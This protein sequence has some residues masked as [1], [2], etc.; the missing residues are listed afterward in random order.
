[1]DL[2]C[3]MLCKPLTV[4]EEWTQ[5][6][7]STWIWNTSMLRFAWASNSNHK[8]ST[9]SQCRKGKHQELHHSKKFLLTSNRVKDLE[10]AI[11]E[12]HNKNSKQ[13]T[14]DKAII[15]L[16]KGPNLSSS[17]QIHSMPNKLTTCITKIRTAVI[18]KHQSN[19]AWVLIPKTNRGLRTILDL[20][21]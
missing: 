19:G 8:I 2:R 3:Q 4:A 16:V 1:M 7:H 9:H 14:W 10:S 12:T 5:I 11:H 13:W 21:I 20:K 6:I 18:F 15:C 17:N